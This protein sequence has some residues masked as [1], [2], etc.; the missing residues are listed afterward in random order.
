MKIISSLFICFLIYSFIGWLYE[1][2]ASIVR[3]HKFINRG[4]LLGPICPL[5]GFGC[6]LITILLEEHKGSIIQ[7]FILTILICSI[8]EYFTGYFMEKIFKTRWWDY[9]YKKYNINGRISLDV[10]LFFGVAGV[11]ILYIVNP[12]LTKL[13]SSFNTTSLYV[14][15]IIIFILFIADIILSTTVTFKIRETIT[16]YEKDSTEEI[17]KKVREYFIK[18]GYLYKRTIEAFPS[19]INSRER[20]LELRKKINIEIDKLNSKV[21]NKKVK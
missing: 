9:T 11:F 16:N 13:I 2:I 5:Y 6:I 3:K 10:M 14:T 1:V 18:R 4:Y 12:L 17:T 15:S 20:L 8:L 21:N 19:M 7:S